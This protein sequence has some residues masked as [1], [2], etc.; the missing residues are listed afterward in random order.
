[1]LNER[2]LLAKAEQGDAVSMRRLGNHFGNEGNFQKAMFWWEKAARLSDPAAMFNLGLCYS[3]QGEFD[4]AVYWFEEAYKH[5]VKEAALE[6]GV[7][8]HGQ[9]KLNDAVFWWEK[10]GDALPNAARNLVQTC[11]NK[12][13]FIKWLTI[14]AE[15]QKDPWGMAVWGT[16]LCG[17]EYKLW[18]DNGFTDLPEPDRAKGLRLI[19]EGVARAESGEDT[20]SFYFYDYD[21]FS[22]AQYWFDGAT[23]F[24]KCSRE[25]LSAAIRYLEKAIESAR[26]FAR[27]NP[28][29]A[30]L[31]Q[32]YE[33]QLENMKGAQKKMKEIALAALLSRAEEIK[34]E[35]EELMK[36]GGPSPGRLQKLKELNEEMQQ[37]AK[38]I[39]RITG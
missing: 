13:D 29:G 22:Q 30:M 9:G 3:E 32:G 4:K 11:T 27:H 23:N 20:M 14:L 5:D 25:E 21:A 1:M 34:K 6:L 33:V 26:E 16:L 12:D 7:L 37:T 36:T 24:S 8:Y 39:K 2:E 18:R 31:A 35:M 19:E 38:E 17:V 10:V 28:L 15:N